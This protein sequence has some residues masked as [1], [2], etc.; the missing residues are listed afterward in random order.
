M[1]SATKTL[2]PES[3]IDYLDEKAYRYDVEGV[4]GF[5][6]VVI[7]D[8]ELPKGYDVAKA[9]LLLRLPA[10]YPNAQ[11]DMFWTH[12]D[13][14]HNGTFPNA[15]DAHDVNYKGKSWQRWSRHFAHAPW[16]PGVDGLRSYVALVQKELQ[17]GSR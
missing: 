10:G 12:P 1:L 14:K 5:I 13:I 2:I 11:P 7:H 4:N 17:K 6:H 8:F 3:A 16:R 15:A 9:D